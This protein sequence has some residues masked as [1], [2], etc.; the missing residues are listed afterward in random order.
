VVA[1]IGDPWT[2][3]RG[4]PRSGRGAWKIGVTLNILRSMAGHFA[5]AASQLAAEEG[6]SPE[7]AARYR[8]AEAL[9][10]DQAADCGLRPR[11]V[12]PGPFVRMENGETAPLTVLFASVY[13]WQRRWL[14]HQSIDPEVV[15]LIREMLR[16][17]RWHLPDEEDERG[18]SP[19][20]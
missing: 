12:R 20:G 3:A 5:V 7:D 9:L 15:L 4:I 16:G 13:D 17:L 18:L 6:I 11:T 1:L 14:P 10:R 8:A 2:I 19:R